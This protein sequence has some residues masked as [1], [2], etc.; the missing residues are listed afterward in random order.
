MDRHI[1]SIRIFNEDLEFIGEIDEFF[2]LYFIRK[3]STY[4]EFEFHVRNF[5]KELL[6]RGNIILIDNDMSKAGIIEYIE[7]SDEN[8]EDIKIK[9]FSLLYMLTYRL[10]IPKDDQNIYQFKNYAS[11]IM[12][13]LVK[14]N[15]II[16][17]SRKIPNLAVGNTSNL[18]RKFEYKVCYTNL[19]DEITKLCNISGLGATIDFD[20][21][22]KKLIFKVLEGKNLTYYQN[23]NPP[24]IFAFEYDNIKSQNYIESSIPMKNCAY[25]VDNNS[26]LSVINNSVS[27][28]NRREMLVDAKKSE[29]SSDV[30]KVALTNLDNNNEICSYE[31]EVNPLGYRDTWD[32]GDIVTSI[33]KKYNFEVNSRVSEVKETYENNCIKV[34]PTF[35]DII[36]TVLDI[37]KDNSSNGSIAISEASYL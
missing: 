10:V 25:A 7:I 8:G 4:G 1:S 3:W 15:A 26:K 33:S 28:L 36:P 12:K 14:D 11:E 30:T 6:K 27:G 17:G 24:A 23:I 29:L 21:I 34:E 13:G 31:C 2:S 22:N 16:E 5:N 19:C 20:Y 9:G 18:G 35:G 37:I 32:I